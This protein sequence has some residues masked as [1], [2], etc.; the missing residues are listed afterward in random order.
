MSLR[1]GWFLRSF[2]SPQ[3]S[4]PEVWRTEVYKGKR[5]QRFSSQ[6]GQQN[7][8]AG[9]SFCKITALRPE[10][11]K[12]CETSEISKG[13]PQNPWRPG[14]YLCYIW[15]AEGWGCCHSLV[16]HYNK[17]QVVQEPQSPACPCSHSCLSQDRA[18]PGWT[19]C[20]RGSG[21]HQ[22]LNCPSPHWK[23]AQ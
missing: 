16:R 12:E 20:W 19:C 10:A 17:S 23:P 2:L 14:L 8:R 21:G 5:Y 9:R 4:L 3:I 13:N 1:K 11:K 22:P 18:G 7:F 15:E 6:G